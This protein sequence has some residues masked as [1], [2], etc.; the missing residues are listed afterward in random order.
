MIPCDCSDV[1]GIMMDVCWLC[2]VWTDPGAGVTL[3]TALLPSKSGWNIYHIRHLTLARSAQQSHSQ[4][5]AAQWT[6]WGGKL[7]FLVLCIMR[8]CTCTRQISVFIPWIKKR[9]ARCVI[10]CSHSY[11]LVTWEGSFL[12]QLFNLLR[13]L[14]SVKKIHIYIFTF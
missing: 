12:I 2:D 9:D 7:S 11:L 13:R 6:N 8:Y 4:P 1:S 3:P 5:P 14:S 10:G